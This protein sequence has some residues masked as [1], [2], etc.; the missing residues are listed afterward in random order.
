M[1]RG[2]L[3][4]C[5][6]DVQPLMQPISVHVETTAFEFGVNESL[7]CIKPL[8]RLCRDEPDKWICAGAVWWWAFNTEDTCEI[9]L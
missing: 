8:E 2:D 9:L 5:F 3:G 1:H 7:N 6:S 4:A